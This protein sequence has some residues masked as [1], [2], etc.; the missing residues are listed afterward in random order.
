MSARCEGD[1]RTSSGAG[2]R[3]GGRRAAVL[4]VAGVRPGGQLA[5]FGFEFVEAEG[6]AIVHNVVDVT[7]ELTERYGPDDVQV[8]VPM[9]VGNY[10][11]Q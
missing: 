7:A 8:I 11:C 5:V 10:G 2:N 3:N 9:N 4:S 6:D 1:A